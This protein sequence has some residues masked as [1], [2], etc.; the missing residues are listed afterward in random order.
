MVPLMYEDLKRVAQH[1]LT[2]ERHAQTLN[3]TALVHEAYLRLIDQNRMRWNG[4]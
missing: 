3:T 1:A 4:M 2:N